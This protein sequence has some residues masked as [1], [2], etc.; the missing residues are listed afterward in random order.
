MKPLSSNYPAWPIAVPAPASLFPLQ[1]YTP[2]GVAHLGL[3]Q[4][5]SQA[6]TMVP[7]TYS[8]QTYQNA[9]PSANP[10]FVDAV[11]SMQRPSGY[12][13]QQAPAYG[14]ALNAAQRYPGGCRAASTP[15][16]SSQGSA[17]K[18]A[19][20]GRGSLSRPAL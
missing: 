14:H 15:T 8:G 1:G 19:L 7:S 2:Y 3:Q 5:P 20:G 6:S 16:L 17:R 13:H 4:H 10:A 12:V 9:H 11:R 18:A